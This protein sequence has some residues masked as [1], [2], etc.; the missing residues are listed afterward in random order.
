MGWIMMQRLKR[1]TANKRKQLSLKVIQ[2]EGTFFINGHAVYTDSIS[3]CHVI[4]STH[5]CPSE[6]IISFTPLFGFNMCNNMRRE[7]VGTTSNFVYYKATHIKHAISSSG[8]TKTHKL[9][10]LR[11]LEQT[12]C[13]PLV[14]NEHKGREAVHR[15][16]VEQWLPF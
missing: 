16:T 10:E 5:V 1:Q 11:W 7:D 6:D 12:A 14:W 13:P 2:F 3:Y 9:S 4:H 8:T 15:C